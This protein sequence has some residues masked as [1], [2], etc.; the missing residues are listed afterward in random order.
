[1]IL[2]ESTALLL[3]VQWDLGDINAWT[4]LFPPF[5]VKKILS[6]MLGRATLWAV[7]SLPISIASVSVPE[8]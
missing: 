4:V 7:Q 5:L 8:V 3:Q 1:M 6:G 2:S